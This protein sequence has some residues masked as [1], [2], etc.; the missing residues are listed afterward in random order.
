MF[1]RP[2]IVLALLI[3]SLACATQEAPPKTWESRSQDH[4]P[5]STEEVAM[6]AHSVDGFPERTTLE[7][8]CFYDVFPSEDYVT[9]GINTKPFSYRADSIQA[10][11][12][13]DSERREEETWDADYY[14]LVDSTTF[15]PVFSRNHRNDKELI[16]KLSQFR[17][18]EFIVSIAGEE[19]VAK[20]RLDGFSDV[21]EPVYEACTQRIGS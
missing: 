15:S 5:F 19:R 14:D 9:V 1:I 13:W 2:V 8:T 7:V 4:G 21:Y 6:T 16:A 12:V 10:V 20:F 3:L 11:V 17:E 18:M